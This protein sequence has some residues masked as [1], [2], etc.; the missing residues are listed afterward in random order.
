VDQLSSC[1]LGSRNFMQQVVGGLLGP[2]HFVDACSCRLLFASSFCRLRNVRCQCNAVVALHARL[3]PN[4]CRELQTGA[5]RCR[6]VCV[7]LFTSCMRRLGPL[8]CMLGP[9]AGC[10]VPTGLIGVLCAGSSS[11]WHRCCTSCAH[12]VLWQYCSNIQARGGRKGSSL[13]VSA[14][15]TGDICVERVK[16]PDRAWLRVVQLGCGCMRWTCGGPCKCIDVTW[17]CFSLAVQPNL[18]CLSVGC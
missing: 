16:V 2:T 5:H 3:T 14:V 9:D 6:M 18:N 4:W 12:F 8:Y 13:L 17:Y 10:C 7:R 11:H 1:G 15:D